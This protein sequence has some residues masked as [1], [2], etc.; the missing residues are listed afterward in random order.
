M[1]AVKL[2]F[3]CPSQNNGTS[4]WRCSRP[5]AKTPA[6]WRSKQVLSGEPVREKVSVWFAVFSVLEQ[7]L[8]ASVAS[9]DRWAAVGDKVQTAAV[10]QSSADKRV[11]AELVQQAAAVPERGTVLHRRKPVYRA[12]VQGI[13]V[14]E[15]AAAAESEKTDVLPS[16]N[17]LLSSQNTEQADDVE[18][19]PSSACFIV[20][21]LAA[22][23]DSLSAI[24][25]EHPFS[26]DE[27][28]IRYIRPLRCS[29]KFVPCADAQCVW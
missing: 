15:Q 20:H 8:A 26:A 24:L 27:S 18:K 29:Q 9:A 10:A 22:F 2:E 14:V 4:R 25:P 19:V 16:E 21:L 28:E 5:T 3:D 17:R 12:A 23:R 13:A 11:A 1:I 6:K 7:A